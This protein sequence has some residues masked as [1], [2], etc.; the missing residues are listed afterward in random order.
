MGEGMQQGSGPG[1][2]ARWWH[3]HCVGSLWDGRCW[4]CSCHPW[5]YGVMG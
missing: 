1:A 2:K 4:P 5:G 3:G